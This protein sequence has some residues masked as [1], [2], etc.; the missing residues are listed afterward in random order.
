M[1]HIQHAQQAHK[2]AYAPYTNF[3]VGAAVLTDSGKIFAGP[4]IENAISGLGICAERVAINH[5]IC[6]GE[7]NFTSI[8]IYTNTPQV[9]WPCGSCLQYL[10]EW[11]QVA[12]HDIAIITHNGKQIEHSSVRALLEHHHG[13]RSLG[14]NIERYRK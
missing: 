5:A 2:Q 8:A 14:V 1:N 11:S 4:N 3:A 10:A 9:I 13:P 7:Y 6:H 12:N